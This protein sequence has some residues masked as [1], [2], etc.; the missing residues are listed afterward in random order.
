MTSDKL[1]FFIL[2]DFSLGSVFHTVAEKRLENQRQGICL[3]V[4]K[5]FVELSNAWKVSGDMFFGGDGSFLFNL[6]QA[7]ETKLLTIVITGHR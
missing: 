4:V 1:D 7:L 3:T 5:V 2:H 6:I